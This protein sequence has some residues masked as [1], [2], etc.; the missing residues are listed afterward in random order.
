MRLLLQHT[1][2]L[3]VDPRRHGQARAVVEVKSA[4]ER[5]HR[6]SRSTDVPGSEAMNASTP[7][8]MFL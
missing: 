6:K 4:I 7:S 2:Y 3:G 8:P 1:L 5:I